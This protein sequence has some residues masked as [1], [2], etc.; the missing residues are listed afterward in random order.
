[1]LPEPLTGTNIEW[2]PSQSYFQPQMGTSHLP[3][4]GTFASQHQVA[5]A[6][7]S[8]A[9]AVMRTGW[10]TRKAQNSYQF[11]PQN[12][13]GETRPGLSCTKENSPWVLLGDRDYAAQNPQPRSPAGQLCQQA[14]SRQAAGVPYACPAGSGCALPVFADTGRK[15]PFVNI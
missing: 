11:H 2:R 5:T 13:E 1:M 6:A 14:P 3:K 15:G 7:P 10:E 9:E 12:G 8:L 4:Q